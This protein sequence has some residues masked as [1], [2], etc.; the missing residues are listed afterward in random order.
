MKE[1]FKKYL[2]NKGYF[3]A[4]EGTGEE[5][6]GEV[7]ISLAN[8]FNIKISEGKELAQLDMVRMAS[9]MLGVYVPE[10]FYKGFPESVK[11]LS[12]FALLWDQLT[13]YLNT[14]GMDRFDSAGH[15][16]FEEITEKKLFAEKTPDHLFAIVTEKDAE[17]LLLRSAEDLLAGSRPLNTSDFEVVASAVSDLG[18]KVKKCG[19]KDTAVKLFL[20]TG[21]KA[22]V[23]FLTVADVMKLVEQM[24]YT[25][26]QSVDVRKLNLKNKDRKMIASCLDV[27]FEKGRCDVKEC[28][29]KKAL[30]AGLIHH[31]HYRPRCE[32][33]RR[34]V[35]VMRGKENLSAYSEFEKAMAA[36]DIKQAVTVLKREKGDS[37]LLRNL[38]YIFSRCGTE[39]ELDSV[40]ENIESRNTVLLIQL[41]A[42]FSRGAE[43]EAPR[44][45]V[46]SKFNKVKVHQE[47]PLE[48]SRRRSRISAAQQLMIKEKIKG[49]I[50]NTLRNKLGRVYV[51]EAMKKVA[52]PVSETSSQSGFGVLPKGTRIPLEEG[53]KLRAFV[54][55]EKVNDIDL[56]CVAIT[57]DGSAVEFSWRTMAE[58]KSDAIIYSGDQTSG[59]NGGSE[60]YDVIIDKF[61]EKYP[62]AE[63]IVF[64]AN[65]YSDGKYFNEC[66]CRAGYMVRDIDDSGEIFEPK[67]VQ[68]S[69]SVNCDSS[70][71]YLFGLDLVR[72]EFVWLNASRNGGVRV[73][74]T[75][76]FGFLKQWLETTDVINVYDFVKMAATELADDPETADIVVSDRSLKTSEGAEVIRSCDID[77]L[78]ALL[79][80]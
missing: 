62:T 1:I 67:T 43:S 19:S 9:E 56:S 70:F 4:E 38:S 11:K 32:L 31:I 74:G 55:W 65:V 69:F 53:K 72:K 77:K 29:E 25:S 8:I 30:W 10:P 3:V 61:T 52:L 5:R 75:T 24:N 28:C 20:R 48:V 76:D 13:H 34:F 64:C 6:P 49:L 40:F 35:G 80:I 46:F 16:I 45:F 22:F 23:D 78:R 7:L 15:S 63:Y 26:Y 42:N 36:N 54:Y 79:S 50:E 60:F 27:L 33:A 73:A 66:V 57:R 44:T 59:Y 18:L 12:D 14:Y 17:K 68:S 47:E 41:L 21:N 58:A 71:G 37:V 51:D 2:F 39:E